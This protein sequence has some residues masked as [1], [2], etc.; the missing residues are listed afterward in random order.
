M[1]THDANALYGKLSANTNVVYLPAGWVPPSASLS[2]TSQLQQSCPSSSW[3]TQPQFPPL[4]PSQSSV[5]QLQQCSP[6]E[7]SSSPSQHSA[8]DEENLTHM[9]KLTLSWEETHF[10]YYEAMN[11]KDKIYTREGT[12]SQSSIFGQYLRIFVKK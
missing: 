10:A 7:P 4:D 1:Y 9:K 3:A 2:A 11:F 12:S 6:I 8:T 5:S